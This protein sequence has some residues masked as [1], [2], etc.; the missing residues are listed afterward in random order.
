MRVFVTGATG[1]IGSAVVQE[2]LGAGHQ[3]V[4]LA[5]SEASAQALLAAGAEVQRGTVEDL[6]SLRRGAA[7]AEGAIHLAFFHEFTHARLPTRLRVLLGG[8]PGGI[9]SRF[10]R[11]AVDTDRRAFEAIGKALTGTDRP[12]VAA[13]GT[14]AMKARQL[15]TEEEAADSGSVGAARGASEAALRAL[16]AD[17]IRTSVIRLPPVVHGDGD[18]AG[19]VPRLIAVTRKQ[20]VSVYIGDGQNRW[21]SVHC[22]DAARLF[23]L[24]LEQGPAGGTYHGVAEEG[25]PFHEISEMIGKKLGVPIADKSPHEAAKL[26]S[27]LAPFLPVDNPTSSKLTQERLGWQPTHPGLLADLDHGS[28]FEI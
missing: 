25:I 4:G 12:L 11:A 7:K 24:A 3:V 5:R 18:R 20:G 26:F 14:L 16:A 19:F 6:D 10:T 1:F 17:G 27:W 28:Y 9:I 21:P 8:S 22:L 15:A 2:L 13:F 23:R